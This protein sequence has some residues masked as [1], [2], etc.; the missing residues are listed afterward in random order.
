MGLP[1]S[2]EFL[3]LSTEFARFSRD[4]YGFIGSLTIPFGVLL[5]SIWYSKCGS[6]HRMSS[7]EIPA[8]SRCRESAE[9]P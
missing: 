6:S 1:W 2:Y 4:F 9:D 8:S 7:P 3:W 5:K